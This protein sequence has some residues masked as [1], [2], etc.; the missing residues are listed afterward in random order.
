MM[1]IPVSHLSLLGMY[2][3]GVV[4]EPVQKVMLPGKS[5]EEFLDLQYLQFPP[6]TPSIS[7]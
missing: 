7:H 3:V 2:S 4:T 5:T 6:P 1:H